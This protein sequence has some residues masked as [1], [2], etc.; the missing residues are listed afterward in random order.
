MHLEKN[1]YT[2]KC[3]VDFCFNVFNLNGQL[4]KKYRALPS[5]GSFGGRPLFNSG[6]SPFV[7][8]LLHQAI[9]MTQDGRP[10]LGEDERGVM[11]SPQLHPLPLLVGPKSVFV[12][13]VVQ[14]AGCLEGEKKI[15]FSQKVNNNIT[16]IYHQTIWL[17]SRPGMR[18]YLNTTYN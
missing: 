4:S 10:D 5:I 16:K 13:K 11:S 2:T 6:L 18:L 7:P 3:I 12:S 1:R 8:G 17:C 9:H 15:N 14:F